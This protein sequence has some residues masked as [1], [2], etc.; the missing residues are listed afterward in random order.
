MSKKIKRHAR[1]YKRQKN[2]NANILN[3]HHLLFIR[4]R[5]RGGAI[6]ELRQFWYCIVDIPKDTLHKYIHQHIISIPVPSETS[7][8][9]ALEQLKLLDDFGV[10]SKTDTV[11]MR[12]N[13]LI[14]IF[15]CM[16]EATADGLR[17]Q[18]AIVNEFNQG[19]SK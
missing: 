4:R 8:R 2:A 5:W 7:A 12:L 16:E 9:S 11:Q 10:L 15:D 13:I 3:G 18:L 17:K 14:A 6:R 1:R 19:S